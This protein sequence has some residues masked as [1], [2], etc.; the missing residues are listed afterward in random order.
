MADPAAP[1]AQ[2][3]RI[4]VADAAPPPPPAPG[5]GAGSD[6]DDGVL[7]FPPLPHAAAFSMLAS[8]AGFEEF[9]ARL[10][11]LCTTTR[12]AVS[13]A[14]IAATVEFGPHRRKAF[15]AAVRTGDARRV[16]AFADAGVTAAT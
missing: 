11:G 12:Y 13:L 8:V 10:D 15:D 7:D 1:P 4:G 5:G 9:F 6:V 2:R 14:A 16:R 3:R